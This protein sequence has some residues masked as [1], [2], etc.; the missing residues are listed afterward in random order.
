MKK[1][2]VFVPALALV[3]MMSASVLAENGAISSATLN[4]MGLGSI[5]TMSDSEALAVRGRGYQGFGSAKAWGSSKSEIDFDLNLGPF[6][7]V[8][9]ETKSDDGFMSKG[10]F[11]AGGEHS[12]E[13]LFSTTLSKTT[14]VSGVGSVTKTL[15]L[16]I[17]IGSGGSASSFSL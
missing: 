3:A 7:N 11:L 1:L 12:S 15:S 17:G 5:A 13:S 9:F 2:S 8:E 16:T 10:N 4:E 6:G 14:D